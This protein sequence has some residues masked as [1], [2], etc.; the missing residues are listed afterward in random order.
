MQK[1]LKATSLK[2][3]ELEIKELKER[4][5]ILYCESIQ[6][7]ATALIKNN[8]DYKEHPT[9]RN[10]ITTVFEKEYTD[11]LLAHESM[12]QAIREEYEL[13]EADQ[14]EQD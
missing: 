12:T 10:L 14:D 3:V 1:I 5:K 13:P 11:N 7:L 6:L 9:I 8:P 4:I 2:V